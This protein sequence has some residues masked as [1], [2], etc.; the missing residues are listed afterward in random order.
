[1]SNLVFLALQIS[2]MP[3]PTVTLCLTSFEIE[4]SE[5]NGGPGNLQAYDNEPYQKEG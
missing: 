2:S 5:L 1:M 4:P 3:I